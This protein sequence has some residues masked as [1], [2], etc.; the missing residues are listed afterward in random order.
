MWEIIDSWTKRRLPAALKCSRIWAQNAATIKI[1][2]QNER[3][4]EIPLSLAGEVC[5][6][7][8]KWQLMVS[9]AFLIKER[10]LLTFSDIYLF[11]WISLHS[12]FTID[13][14][15]IISTNPSSQKQYLELESR[16]VWQATTYSLSKQILNKASVLSNSFS[17]A[18]FS[19]L[20][21]QTRFQS[22]SKNKQT[23]LFWLRLT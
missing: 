2:T 16:I 19:L 15:F 11:C 6:F 21:A 7:W 5:I 3:F 1:F 12:K 8:T 13:P 14:K 18:L 4:Q 20:V 22:P 17:V 23:R 9:W 10:S